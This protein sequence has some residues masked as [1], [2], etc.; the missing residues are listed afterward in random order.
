M[1]L[2]FSTSASSARIPSR[3]AFSDSDAIS[4]ITSAAD[5]PLWNMKRRMYPGTIFIF[6]MGSDMKQTEIDPPPTI[7]TP[8]SDQNMD[9]CPWDVSMPTMPRHT[10]PMITPMRLALSTFRRL[11]CSGSQDSPER[12]AQTT[13]PCR[14]SHPASAGREG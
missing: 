2:I 4:W 1:S 7:S 5:L 6:S 8:S 14:Q 9:Q 13:R 12:S 11:P 3:R 10:M